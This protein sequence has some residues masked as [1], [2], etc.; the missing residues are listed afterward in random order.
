MRGKEEEGICG[1]YGCL[2]VE[3]AGEIGWIYAGNR[4]EKGGERVCLC[5][6]LMRI[7]ENGN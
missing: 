1:E 7:R 5:C 3:T 6:L 4:N 2:D